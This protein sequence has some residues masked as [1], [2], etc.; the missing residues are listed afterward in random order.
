MH[1]KKYSFLVLALLIIQVSLIHAQHEMPATI[2]GP[3]PADLPGTSKNTIYSASAIELENHGYLEEEYFIKGVANRYRKPKKQNGTIIDGGHPYQ[4]RFI[5][6][7]PKEA[8]HFNGIVMVEWINVTAGPD[9]DINWWM[10]GDH[11]M[12]KG[13][14]YIGV[15]AQ[16]MGINTMKDWSPERYKN[17]DVSNNGKIEKDDLSFDVFAAVGMTIRQLGKGSK[18]ETIDFLGG[19]RPKLFIATGHSQSAN[20]LATYVNSI[21]PLHPIYDGFMIHGGGGSIRTDLEVKVFKVLAESDMIWQ[22]KIRQPNSNTFHQWEVA[23]SSHVD[24]HFELQYGK[25]RNI[26]AGKPNQKVIPRKQECDLPAY[27]RVPFMDVL[28]AAYEHLVNWVQDNQAPPT[29]GP[30][31]VLQTAPNLELARDDYGN[32]LGGIRLATHAVPTAKNTGMNPGA[33][34]FC[35]LYGS[36]EPFDEQT[37]KQLYPTHDA[38]VNAVENVVAQNLRDGFILPFAAE[39]TL[40]DAKRFGVG[41]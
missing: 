36:H 27:S 12:R 38:Y 1:L 16:Q 40:E 32:V 5:V 28:N 3:I 11:F 37:I 24:L 41:R 19:L 39:R 9:K 7:R 17:L 30:L 2:T 15:S 35:R 23:G 29:A 33:N 18:E 26:R 25:V 13:Y 31:V 4:T 20:R 14:A 6:R 22:A 21:H 34:W 8:S 10:S